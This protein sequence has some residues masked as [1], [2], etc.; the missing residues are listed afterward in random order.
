MSTEPPT[1]YEAVGGL[2]FFEALVDR[3][4][5]GV[6]ADPD[7]LALYPE[8]QHLAPARRR[9]ALF[10]AEYWGG[11]PDYS[12]ERGHPRLRIRHAAFPIGEAQ[13]DAWL[14]HMR[15]AVEHL[16]P[17]EGVAGPLLEYFAMGAEAV[18]NR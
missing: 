1:F 12:E 13:R 3:F 4:Y 2:P 14:A 16:A 17:P 10:L 5:E 18:R 15:A 7:L 6:A 8:P 11:P 9:L